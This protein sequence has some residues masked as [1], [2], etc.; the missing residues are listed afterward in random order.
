MAPLQALSRGQRK[1]GG[2]LYRVVGT[3]L[4]SVDSLGAHTSIGAISGSERCIMRNTAAQLI[5]VSDGLVWAYTVAGGLVSVTDADIVGALAV[6]LINNQFVYSKPDL[7]VISDVGDGST[8]SG[9]NAAQAE[10]QP[11]ELIR[12]YVFQ[13]NYL[14]AWRDFRRSMA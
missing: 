3:T 7:F 13:P 5:I 1:M 9:L 2:L 4:Y 8:A 11:D 14:Y 10:S 6:D 12:A